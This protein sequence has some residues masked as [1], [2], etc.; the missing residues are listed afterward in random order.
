[1]FFTQNIVNSQAAMTGNCGKS[2]PKGQHVN[3]KLIKLDANTM[4]YHHTFPHLKK[5]IETRYNITEMK[6]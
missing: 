3:G 2:K 1:M 5:D 6:N 4:E